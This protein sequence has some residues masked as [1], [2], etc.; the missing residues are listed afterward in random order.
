MDLPVK[1]INHILHVVVL[2]SVF[3]VMEARLHDR[4]KGTIRR[5][6]EIAEVFGVLEGKLETQTTQST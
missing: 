1:K 5:V 3:I 6:T 2:L 4:K